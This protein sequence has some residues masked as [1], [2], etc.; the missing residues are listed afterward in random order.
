MLYQF[1]VTRDCFCRKLLSILNIF[2]FFHLFQRKTVIWSFLICLCKSLGNNKAIK[3]NQIFLIARS[4]N[5]QQ[6]LSPNLTFWDWPPGLRSI[7]MTNLETFKYTAEGVLL[8]R[9][10]YSDDKGFIGNYFRFYLAALVYLETSHV[11]SCFLRSS[12]WNVSTTSCCGW[13][14]LTRSTY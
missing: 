3:L 14:Y 1:L 10:F 6:F 12:R 7:T 13:P 4:T 2:E 9:T 5:C 11:S 8:V